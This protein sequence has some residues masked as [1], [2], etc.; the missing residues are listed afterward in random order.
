MGGKGWAQKPC[1]P[2]ALCSVTKR[3][4]LPGAL[5]LEDSPFTLEI[6]KDECGPNH[7][8]Q[9]ANFPVLEKRGLEL[10]NHPLLMKNKSE[11]VKSILDSI[12]KRRK[13]IS[14]FT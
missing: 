11:V 5:A 2:G 7:S 4:K 8:S 6:L 3:W 10:I 12:Q 1:A 9:N 13:K 14:F